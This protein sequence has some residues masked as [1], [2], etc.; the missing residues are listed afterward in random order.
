MKY[1]KFICRRIAGKTEKST[2]IVCQYF[3]MMLD[4]IALFNESV[5]I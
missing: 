5:I 3:V 1:C 2:E 4:F